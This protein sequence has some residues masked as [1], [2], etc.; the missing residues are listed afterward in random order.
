MKRRNNFYIIKNF[1][2]S[3]LSKINSSL[4]KITNIGVNFFVYLLILRRLGLSN[5]GLIYSCI[6]LNILLVTFGQFGFQYSIIKYISQYF[7]KDKFYQIKKLI[8]FSTKIQ[9]FI[10]L[11]ISLL[12]IICIPQLNQIL[13]SEIDFKIE[14]ALFIISIPFLLIKDNNA[15]IIQGLGYPVL[16]LSINTLLLPTFLSLGIL[17]FPFANTTYFS[18]IHFISAFFI[19]IIS[20]KLRVYI[21][22]KKSA[23]KTFN[24]NDFFDKLSFMLFSLNAWKITVLSVFIPRI[25]E[26]LVS[27]FGTPID[28]SIFSTSLRIAFLLNIPMVGTNQ[29]ISRT[30]AS[31]HKLKDFDEISKISMKSLKFINIISLPIFIFILLFPELILNIFSNELI[32]SGNILRILA[33]SIF[34]R[35]MFGP[36][37][38]ILSMCGFEKY[39]FKSLLISFLI[40]I[41]SCIYLLPKIGLIGA[42][43]SLTMGNLCNSTLLKIK[44]NN[45]IKSRVP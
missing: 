45:F 6:N 29:V 37:E 41:S 1:Y 40:S 5:A 34:V 3:N 16:A 42:C 2:N 17:F 10:S 9:V 12:F 27:V 30:I 8:N 28:V 20:Y 32:N 15:F 11:F 18:F 38:I 33:I 43:V 7:I 4:V 25:I 23:N 26:F 14:L 44:Y 39:I 35:I 22:S 21:W 31:N 36:N 13:F 19:C 24:K